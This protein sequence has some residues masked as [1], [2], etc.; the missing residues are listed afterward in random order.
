MTKAQAIAEFRL[1]SRHT[2]AKGDKVWRRELWNNYTDRLCK[3]GEITQAQY[4]S[5]TN[6]F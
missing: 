3:D 6:P 2:I 4:D 5:W 1:I